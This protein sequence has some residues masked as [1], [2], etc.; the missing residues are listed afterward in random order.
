MMTSFPSSSTECSNNRCYT[1]TCSHQEC[2]PNEPVNCG[3]GCHCLDLGDG[4]K[5][6]PHPHEGKL[7]RCESHADC[8]VGTMKDG[9]GYCYRIFGAAQGVCIPKPIKH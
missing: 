6:Q 8:S 3:Y 2:D 9:V 1:D 4:N 5:C 7:T